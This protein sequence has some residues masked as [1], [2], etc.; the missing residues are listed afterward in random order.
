VVI[1]D[2]LCKS[3]SFNKTKFTYKKKGYVTVIFISGRDANVI[4]LDES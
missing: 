2:K 3:Y 4:F 1:S